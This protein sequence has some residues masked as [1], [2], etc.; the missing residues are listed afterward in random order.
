MHAIQ[1]PNQRATGSF[2]QPNVP[3]LSARSLIKRSVKV[4]R[5]IRFRSTLVTFAIHDK[6]GIPF[7]FLRWKISPT[8]FD[9]ESSIR[10]IRF[11]KNTGTAFGNHDGGVKSTKIRSWHRWHRVEFFPCRSIFSVPRTANHRESCRTKRKRRRAIPSASRVALSTRRTARAS[12]WRGREVASRDEGTS[13]SNQRI[14]TPGLSSFSRGIQ[15]EAGR[16]KAATRKRKACRTFA[17]KGN[18]C[19]QKRIQIEFLSGHRIERRS[20]VSG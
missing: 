10:L 6:R 8:P 17:A 18:R 2:F 4:S 7:N 20:D 16:Q 1:C 9:F 3:A 19:V 15:L 13:M 5:A 11:A 14:S 12:R